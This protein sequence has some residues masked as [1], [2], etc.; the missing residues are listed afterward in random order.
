MAS[1]SSDV[2]GD[3]SDPIR[4]G[5]IATLKGLQKEPSFNGAQATTMND[6][7]EMDRYQ[8]EAVKKGDGLPQNLLIE[9]KRVSDSKQMTRP[10]RH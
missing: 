8:V 2:R 6:V 1:I 9:R 3:V 10:R 5:S 4:V 7:A